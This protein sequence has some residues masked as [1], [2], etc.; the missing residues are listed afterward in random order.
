MRKLLAHS[1]PPAMTDVELAA[2]FPAD[3]P[4]ALAIERHPQEP[5]KALLVFASAK[6]SLAAFKALVGLETPDSTGRPQ[7]G[8]WL[9][10]AHCALL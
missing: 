4:A 6:A 2:L 1:L 9:G 10:P 3:A 7:V 8:G 5:R